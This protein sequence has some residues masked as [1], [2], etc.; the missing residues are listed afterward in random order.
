M[1]G[2]FAFV[3]EVAHAGRADD[4]GERGREVDAELALEAGGRG[5]LPG[6]L[7]D[8]RMHAKI[9]ALDGVGREPMVVAKLNARIDRRVNDDAAGEGLVGVQRDLERPA[10]IAGDLAIVP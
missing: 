7:E 3:A 8:E 2:Y 9:D 6:Q 1:A 5:L 4:N 10:E